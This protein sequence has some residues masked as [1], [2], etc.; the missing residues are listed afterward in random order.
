M[1]SP[2]R[3]PV[4]ALTFDLH[5]VIRSSVGPSEYSLFV[6]QHCSR[7]SWDVVTRSA[8]K[9]DGLTNWTRRTDSPNTQ[10]RPEP[11]YQ[12]W[13]SWSRRQKRWVRD[14]EVVEWVGN[15]KG[16]SPP[17]P[18][19][20]SGERYKLP[21]RSPGPQK[22]LLLLSNY[23]SRHA[24]RCNVC[25]KLTSFTAD[26]WLRKNVFCSMSRFW[27]IEATVAN[28]SVIFLQFLRW[29]VDNK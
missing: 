1:P 29:Q 10:C 28:A 5:N 24:S 15:E 14:A 13:K 11:A 25:W 16:Y 3:Q 23:V 8:Q 9:M 22:T 27:S 4:V 20:G 6:Y 18:T 7:S 17:Q 19:W 12:L 2:P 26:R 21:Q